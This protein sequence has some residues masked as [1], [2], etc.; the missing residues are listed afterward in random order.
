[1]FVDYQDE[2][3]INTENHSVNMTTLAGFLRT[4]KLIDKIFIIKI[5]KIIKP[6]ISKSKP[7]HEIRKFMHSHEANAVK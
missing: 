5:K 7:Q 6:I 1:M 2:C 4:V 3:S